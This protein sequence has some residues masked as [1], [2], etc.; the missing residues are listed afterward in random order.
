[1]SPLKLVAKPAEQALT[2]WSAFEPLS[3]RERAGM[4]EAT[5]SQFT[6]AAGREIPQQAQVSSPHIVLE[7]WACRA[8]FF[9]DGRRQ[10]LSLLLPGDAFRMDAAELGSGSTVSALTRVTLCRAP[11]ADQPHSGLALAFAD[12]EAAEKNS[13][14]RQVARLG[15]MSAYERTADFLLEVQERLAAIGMTSGNSF[16][17][18]IT[19]EALADMLGL[20]SVHVNRTLQSLRQDGMLELRGGMARLIDAKRLRDR[21]DYRP[22]S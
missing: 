2:R 11:A 18:P 7:G 8:R 9:P 15:R 3:P 1:M 4:A 12:R 21:V 14:L 19:Q 22:F 5:R 10:I 17:L 16:P 6:V 20:T 13:L